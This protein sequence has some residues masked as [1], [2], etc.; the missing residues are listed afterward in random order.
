MDKVVNFPNSGVNTVEN[1]I[2]RQNK[3]YLLGIKDRMNEEYNALVRTQNSQAIATG[4]IISDMLHAIVDRTIKEFESSNE[5]NTRVHAPVFLNQCVQS[6]NA[7]LA[8]GVISPLT[9]ADEEWADTTVP[10]DV[11]QQF[12]FKYRGKEYS[13]AI[14]SVQINIRYPKIYR[15]NNDNRLAHRIDYFQFHDATKPENVHL[16]EDSIRFI[17]FP[18]TMKALHSHCVVEDKKISDYLDFYYDEIAN[19]LVYPDQTNDDPHSYVIAPKIP[20][21]MLEEEGINV[22]EEIAAF[23][24]SINEAQIPNLDDD[25]DDDGF[26]DSHSQPDEDI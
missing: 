16:T 13:I 1:E 3:I 23:I 12:K 4:K 19:G 7:I 5:L 26:Y 11:G 21:Y 18:Y 10:E 25:D 17:E 24:K 14:E 9:G 8:G 20:F 2:A 22:E 6:L 15:L